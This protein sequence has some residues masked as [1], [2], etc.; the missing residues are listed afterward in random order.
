[1]KKLEVNQ[2]TEDLRE[3]KQAAYDAASK[4][5]DGGTCNL[6]SVFLELPPRT[7]TKMIE[8]ALEAAELGGCVTTWLS[9]RGVLIAP[10]LVGQADRRATAMEAMLSLMKEKGYKVYGYYQ[11]D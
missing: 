8:T 2:L 5:E 1:M 11:M 9:T 6:D 7:R 4:V 3:A 10:P